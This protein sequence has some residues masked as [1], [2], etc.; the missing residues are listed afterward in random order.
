MAKKILITGGTG[1]LGS[2]LVR[3]A[4][5][6]NRWES[7]HATY[8]SVN[9]NYHKVF[10]HFMDARNLIRTFLE[11]IRPDVII[12]TL[13]MSSPDECEKKKLDSWQINVETVK[14]INHYCQAH[15]A[16]LV[17]TSTDLVFDGEKGNYAETDSPNPVN[18]Y[19]DTKYEAEQEILN[20]EHTVRPAVIR[21]SLMYGINLNLQPTFF[22]R[23]LH[24]MHHRQ[25]LDLF[26]DQYRTMISV[27]NAAECLLEIAESDFSGI[28][29]LAGPERINRY[30]FGVRLAAH[31]G[32][33]NDT[34]KSSNIDKAK[35]TARRPADVSLNNNLAVSILKTPILS[36]DDGLESIFENKSYKELIA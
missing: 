23:I 1:T 27:S 3:Q 2:H 34:L 19:G 14:E 31:L 26:Q 17:F 22:H 29:H 15:S 8:Y 28:L 36:I 5:T 7:V 20:P 9:P 10:W 4:V 13:A 18:F 33:P 16:R 6:G 25:D 24:S 21:L 35:L 12:H 32:L 30:N 11:K